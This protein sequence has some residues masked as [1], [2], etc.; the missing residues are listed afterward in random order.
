MAASTVGVLH[1]SGRRRPTPDV[2]DRVPAP[3]VFD[4]RFSW[5]LV[6]G[7]RRLRGRGQLLL[8]LGGE[9][10]GLLRSDQGPH[11]HARVP[12]FSRGD[13]RQQHV[14]LARAG[15]RPQQQRRRLER[16]PDLHEDLRQR[17]AGHRA[18][19]SRTCG[20]ATT[21]ATRRSTPTP[22]PPSS[23]PPCPSLTWDAVRGS[24]QLPGERHG[25][26]AAEPATGRRQSGRTPR[27]P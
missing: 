1:G 18:R 6:A 14:L 9:L 20:C 17:A 23:T 12:P 10:Q 5:D 21:S 4:P 19:A 3:E 15:D 27:R 25:V 2:T 7:R 8:R 24:L 22:A 11:L 16:R 26:R 13:P